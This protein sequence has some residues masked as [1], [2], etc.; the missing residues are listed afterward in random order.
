LEHLLQHPDPRMRSKAALLIGRRNKSADWVEQS[1]QEPD[2][3][4]RANAIEG[5]WGADEDAVRRLFWEMA[6]DANNRVVGNALMG[7]YLIGDTRAIT[8]TLE[9]AGHVEP[10]FRATAAWVMGQAGDPRFRTAL[11]RM[12]VDRDR[13]VRGRAFR[14]LST[15]RRR[16]A[17]MSRSGCVQVHLWD[18]RRISATER[19]VR[20]TV[21]DLG[22]TAVMPALDVKQFVVTEGSH[23]ITAY[24][25][26]KRPAP[27]SLTIG[28]GLPCRNESGPA[29]Y[30]QALLECL[31][32]KR[33]SHLWAVMRYGSESR[34]SRG[35]DEEID[36][37]R[38]TAK[39]EDLVSLVEKPSSTPTGGLMDAA[40]QLLAGAASLPGERHLVLIGSSQAAMRSE[41]EANVIAGNA[42]DDGVV[43]HGLAVADGD[44]EILQVLCL[45]TGGRLLHAADDEEIAAAL[46]RIC[47]GLQYQDEIHYHLEQ[48]PEP[49]TLVRVQAWS[50][51]GIAED[52]LT[53]E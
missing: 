30:E 7:L 8:R 34:T 45:A 44:T 28:F 19:Q 2:P 31:R 46:R 15:I 35:D 11:G 42:R 4:V 49:Q 10:R 27:V 22:G 32:G 40:R 52:S 47:W 13:M 5:L 39:T 21:V 9:V 3:R 53:L 6:W 29:P 17:A 24:E 50:E 51:L 41:D 1:K 43:I 33:S 18:A 26:R 14:S 36:P 20:A 23:L 16:V 37:A 48:S 38:F 25:L 12:L